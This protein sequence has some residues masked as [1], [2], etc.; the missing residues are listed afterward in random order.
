MGR[1]NKKKLIKVLLILIFVIVFINL[2]VNILFRSKSYEEMYE[3]ENF[4]ITEKY[5]SEKELYFY[6]VIDENNKYDFIIEDDFV[7]N[8]KLIE[9][10]KYINE[11]CIEVKGK[12]NFYDICLD[13]N[14]NY[15]YIEVDNSKELKEEENIIIYNSSSY[16]F[17]FWNYNGFINVE[18]ENI[19]KIKIY[20]KDIY[21]PESIYQLDN[22]IYIPNYDN[23]VYYNSYYLINTD[24]L[25]YKEYKLSENIKYNLEFIDYTGDILKLYDKTNSQQLE[26]NI[27]KETI[28]TKNKIIYSESEINLLNQNEADRYEI[29]EDS[30]IYTL[31]EKE[32]ILKIDAEKILYQKEDTV[33]YIEENIIYE[34]NHLEGIKK[35]VTNTNWEFDT[36]YLVYI[37]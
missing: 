26:I 31:G 10:I 6:T 36:Q 9:E 27:F 16:N 13:D 1:L 20:N 24:N 7:D 30:I 18:K 28:K 34:F 4:E 32:T 11:S 29:K 14:T 25:N 21:F 23:E 2:L 8:K 17:L 37:Y 12:I 3:I 35:L 15:F 22:Y 33:I 5:D 19:E